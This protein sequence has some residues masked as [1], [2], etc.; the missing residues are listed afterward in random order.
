MT[1]IEKLKAEIA[2][3]KSKNAELQAD[4]DDLYKDAEAA[5]EMLEAIDGKAEVQEAADNELG[6]LNLRL[7]GLN[8][9]PIRLHS[10]VSAVCGWVSEK[11][12]RGGDPFPCPVCQTKLKI[13][14]RTVNSG[15]ARGVILLHKLHGQNP[16]DEWV[17]ISKH[18]V[19][20][21]MCQLFYHFERDKWH[22]WN[23]AIKREDRNDATGTRGGYWKESDVGAGFATGH[24]R[25][26]KTVYTLL[27]TAL[28]ESVETID[29]VEA[30]GE[31]FDF[32]EL[33]NM[34]ISEFV[35]KQQKDAEAKA[36]A[37]A[38]ANGE[39]AA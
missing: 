28:A 37:K 14:P 29:I 34:P 19:G 21:A 4:Y 39:A 6:D 15:I 10:H 35:E 8:G 22:L 12:K 30:L 18:S 17:R 26:P 20:L 38:K 16:N 32:F 36:K 3:L 1:E 5:V 25:V 11:L 33:M 13:Y 23:F 7:G 31:H 27:N 2:E 9:V 24:L